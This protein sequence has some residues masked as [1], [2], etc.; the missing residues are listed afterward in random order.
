MEGLVAIVGPTAVGKSELA[1]QIAQE[2]NGEI[3][4]ADSRQIYRYMDIGTAKPSLEQRAKV[5]HYLIDIVDP[6]VLFSLALYQKLAYEAIRDIWKRQ[7]LP[8]LV[9][10]SGL[11]VWATIEGWKIPKV[12]PDL[13]F[14]QELEEKAKRN[15]YQALYDELKKVDLVSAQRIAPTNVRRIIRALEIYKTTG[16][17]PF[18]MWHKEIPEFP[19]HIIGLYT[20]RAA[21][22]QRIDFRVDK[23]IKDGLVEETKWL[24]DEG[25]SIALPSMSGIGYK[26]IAMSLQGKLALTAAIQQIKYETH[27]LARHQYGWFRLQDD[28]IHWFEAGEKIKGSVMETIKGFIRTI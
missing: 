7:R 25:Y 17:M 13:K 10:G 5:P 24:L 19:I 12:L 23:M 26:Q 20:E 15:G 3:I 9:G 14:R 8:F 6:D 4:S 1:F 22:Y 16:C 21:L 2:L 28:R 18:Q 27:R 11:Y